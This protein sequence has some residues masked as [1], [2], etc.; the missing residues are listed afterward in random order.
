MSRTCRAGVASASHERPRQCR[1]AAV[2]RG[3]ALEALCGVDRAMRCTAPPFNL[4]CFSLTVRLNLGRL[5][6][7]TLHDLT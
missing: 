3:S 7:A 2:A 1:S 6:W 5:G 4:S